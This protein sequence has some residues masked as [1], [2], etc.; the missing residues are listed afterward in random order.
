[1]MMTFVFS[2]EAGSPAFNGDLAHQASAH[3]IAKI[4]VGGGAGGTRI[5]KVDRMKDLRGGGVAM[6]IQEE[7]HDRIALRRAA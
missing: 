2:V 3:Q 4:V 1:M 6:A 7:C 5:R